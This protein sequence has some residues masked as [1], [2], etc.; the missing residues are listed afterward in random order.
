[1]FCFNNEK[2][3]EMFH[4]IERATD[5]L[6]KGCILTRSITLKDLGGIYSE[7]PVVKLICPIITKGIA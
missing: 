1:M 4:F 5:Y 7:L 6:S 2:V 3:K